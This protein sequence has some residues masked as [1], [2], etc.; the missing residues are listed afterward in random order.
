MFIE[1]IYNK[2]LRPIIADTTESENQQSKQQ[3][4]RQLSAVTNRQPSAR[5]ESKARFSEPQRPTSEQEK[6][7]INREKTNISVASTGIFDDFKDNT[8]INSKNKIQ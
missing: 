5:P 7:V 1:N 6:S 2:N 8:F 4:I 3:N